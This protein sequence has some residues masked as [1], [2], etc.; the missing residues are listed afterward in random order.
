M[1]QVSRRPNLVHKVLGASSIGEDL[2][3]ADHDET[4]WS[5]YL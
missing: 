3:F 1:D 4:L 2:C 5:Y